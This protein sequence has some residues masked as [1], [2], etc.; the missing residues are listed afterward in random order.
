MGGQIAA[1][2][3]ARWPSAVR[4]LTLIEPHGLA[5]SEVTPFEASLR[6]GSVPL[7]V[8]DADG[9]EQFLDLVFV[10]RPF[11]PGPIHR[12][13]RGQMIARAPLWARIWG[14]VRPDATSLEGLLPRIQAPTLVLWGDSDRVFPRSV[15]PALERGL[16]SHQTVLLTG[17]GHTAMMEQP[18]AAAGHWLRFLQ[19]FSHGERAGGGVQE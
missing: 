11:L 10:K 13:L 15:I 18:E 4:T 16:A 17:C 1:D 14:D 19:V 7:I 2:L 12:A 9:Y 6:R 3:A 8:A 5:S